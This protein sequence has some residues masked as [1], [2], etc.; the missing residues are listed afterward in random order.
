MAALPDLKKVL[1]TVIDN[2]GETWTLK[3]L[4]NKG[5]Y[6][7]IFSCTSEYK[8]QAAVKVATKEN[9]KNELVIYK[10]IK[11]FGEKFKK[12]NNLDYLPLAEYISFYICENNFIYL[13]MEKCDGDC[14]E[15]SFN[16]KLCIF[17][18]TWALQFLHNFIIH[19]DI[20]PSNI[21]IKRGKV[22]KFYLI[23][24]GLSWRMIGDA[25]FPN[26]YYSGSYMNDT[27]FP[28]KGD[29]FQSLAI[30]YLSFIG[31]SKVID[32][33]RDIILRILHEKKCE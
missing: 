2:Y 11:N 17:Q 13:F 8:K 28:S 4:I 26:Y 9:N 10:N 27:R 21:L 16:Y 19:C 14:Y 12:E 18:L 29:D 30:T 15:I 24:Y 1:R 23:D 22:D 32:Y 33:N 31:I 3:E 5:E 20:K 6:G 7:Y 25:Y